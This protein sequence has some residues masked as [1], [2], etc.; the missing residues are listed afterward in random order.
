MAVCEIHTDQ[1]NALQKMAALRVIVPEGRPGPFPVVYLLHGLSDDHSAWTRRSNI[2]RHAQAYPFLV[3]MPDGGRG[4]YTD[5]VGSPRSQYETFLTRD[6]VGFI[7]NTFQTVR[8]RE[9][10]FITGFSMGG[11]GAMKLALKHPDLYAGIASHA[12]ALDITGETGSGDDDRR[13]ELQ[14]VFGASPKGGKDDC[15]AVASALS[16]DQFPAIRIDCGIEDFLLGHNRKFHAHLT[17]LGVPHEYVE[18]T[19]G[20]DWPYVDT[21][22]Q[23]TLAFFAGL[24]D[25]RGA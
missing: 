19:G 12:G 11:Y 16:V 8:G 25:A 4:W 23:N 9:G 17:S 3:V 24:W 14:L 18:P 5:A 10:R 15:F 21:H 7:D 6:L 2:E 13:R 1:D 20:H 22:I